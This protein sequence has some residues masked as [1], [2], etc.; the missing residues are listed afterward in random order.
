MLKTF[1]QNTIEDIKLRLRTLSL[2]RWIAICGQLTAV[3]ISYYYFRIQFNILLV[4]PL[5]FLSIILNIYVTARN[6]LIKILSFNETFSYLIFDLVQLILLLSLTGGLTNPFCVLILAPIII[7]ATYLDLSRTIVI[8]IIS[9]ISL[10]LLAFFYYP[11]ES[12]P[13]GINKDDFSNFEIFS[14]WSALVIALI[15]IG[16]YCFRVADESRKTSQALKQTQFALS[17][18]EKV[19]ALMGLT[20]AAVHE[21]GTP[22]STISIA[23]KELVNNASKKDSNYE[24][25]ILIQ[26]QLKRC[27]DI[28]D[29]LRTNNFSD[30]S[31]EFINRLDFHRL[32]NE[33]LNSYSDREVEFIVNIEEYFKKNHITVSRSPE[34]IQ[35][36]T[37]IIDNAVKFS[38]KNVT[39]NLKHNQDSIIVEVIDDGDGFPQDIF[40]LLGEPY[41]RNT[42]KNKHKG[43]GL[44]LFISKNLLAKNFGDIKFLNLKN[45]GGCVQ[46]F[47]SKDSL[48][49]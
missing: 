25:L 11:L 15:F 3:A 29:R 40:P 42:A 38:K 8:G 13:L 18:E 2:I 45:Q 37:N 27:S 41:V 35:S 49:I 17:N 26:S 21:L 33:L 7:S 31:N 5:I 32:V 19:S 24:D 6:P 23:A 22:L 14:I 48:A 44:G 43:L 47:L 9:I 28:L 1:N 30:Q 16:A 10:T 34:I 36:L 46:V 39:I 4:I 20:A 12:L